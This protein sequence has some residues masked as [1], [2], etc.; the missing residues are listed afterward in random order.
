MTKQLPET[1]LYT[2]HSRAH[3]AL[4]AYLGKNPRQMPTASFDSARG[5]VYAFLL[6]AVK[7]QG[8]DIADSRMLPLGDTVQD[9]VRLA[10]GDPE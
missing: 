4:C 1:T 9:L 8:I 3:T 5:V 7:Y 2:L 10:L 6:D